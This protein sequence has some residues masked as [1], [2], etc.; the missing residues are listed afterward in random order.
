MKLKNNEKEFLRE[1]KGKHRVF[2]IAGLSNMQEIYR[3]LS[4]NYSHVYSGQKRLVV[5]SKENPN[6]VIKLGITSEAIIDNGKEVIATSHIKNAILNGKFGGLT[7]TPED[8]NLFA[9]ANIY[10]ND[11][12]LVSQEKVIQFHEYEPFVEWYKLNHSK[13]SNI[14]G[15]HCDELRTAITV[16]I[17]TNDEFRNQLNRIMTILIHLLIVS[18]ISAIKEPLNFGIKEVNG[19]VYLALCDMGSLTMKL[20]DFNGNEVLPSCPLCGTGNMKY[21]ARHFEADD[22]VSIVE[23]FTENL[24]IEGRYGCSNPTCLLHTKTL[25][26]KSG[27]F[28]EDTLDSVVH[29]N[30]TLKYIEALYPHFAKHALYFNPSMDSINS[31]DDYIFHLNSADPSIT[32]SKDTETLIR[33]Y[34]NYKMHSISSLSRVKKNKVLE[35]RTDLIEQLNKYGQVNSPQ[36]VDQLYDIF[37]DVF[38]DIFGYDNPLVR[39]VVLFYILEAYTSTFDVLSY[40]ELYELLVTNDQNRFNSILEKQFTDAEV[41]EKLGMLKF[42]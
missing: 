31:L 41:I 16:Y 39:Y 35:A 21:I 5:V 23:N 25:L 33:M 17:M 1:I 20:N 42:S 4:E 40:A 18:D 7:F 9:C 15:L 8:L 10:D 24:K 13:I 36:M 11:L 22:V 32:S 37:N 12:Y 19:K 29:T 26:N 27:N 6:T 3:D 14:G 28:T 30:Y 2:G 38:K 34:Y